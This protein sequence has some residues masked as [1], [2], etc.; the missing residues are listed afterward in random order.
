[1]KTR[2]LSILILFLLIT[3]VSIPVVSAET[4]SEYYYKLHDMCICEAEEDLG[5]IPYLNWGIGYK[6]WI[7][8]QKDEQNDKWKVF[9]HAGSVTKELTITPNTDLRELITLTDFIEN[10]NKCK[11]ETD[12]IP[13]TVLESLGASTATATLIVTGALYDNAYLAAPAGI[14]GAATVEEA[15]KAVNHWNNAIKAQENA[16]K[17]FREL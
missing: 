6:A 9:V 2:V 8:K 13:L 10:V 16:E 12:E 3:S 11:E 14:T 17:L 5:H 4:P 1:M 7:D 15:R